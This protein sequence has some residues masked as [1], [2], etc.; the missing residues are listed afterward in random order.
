MKARTTLSLQ[1]FDSLE[2][3]PGILMIL[4][5][6]NLV[7]FTSFRIIL[8]ELILEDHHFWGHLSY[9]DTTLHIS[10]TTTAEANFIGVEKANNWQAFHPSLMCITKIKQSEIK[11]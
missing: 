7:W 11:K 2:N 1:K 10:I 9:R 3:S 8:S 6:E 4:F 5:L